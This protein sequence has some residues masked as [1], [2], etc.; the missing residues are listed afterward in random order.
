[1]YALSELNGVAPKQN[2]HLDSDNS[3]QLSDDQHVL[4]STNRWIHCNIPYDSHNGVIVIHG[5]HQDVLKEEHTIICPSVAF[6]CS[7]RYTPHLDWP[8]SQMID[9]CVYR[10][11]TPSILQEFSLPFNLMIFKRSSLWGRLDI[12][13]FYA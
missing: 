6:G 9:R 5:E 8:P 7:L 12:R 2:I 4:H 11:G 10:A 3:I 13:N 1:M